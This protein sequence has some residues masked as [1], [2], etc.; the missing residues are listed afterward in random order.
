LLKITEKKAL[1]LQGELEVKLKK[2][3]YR[4]RSAVEKTQKP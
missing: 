2:V 4:F 1:L 3:Y